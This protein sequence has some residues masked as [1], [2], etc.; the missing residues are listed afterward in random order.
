[1]KDEEAE[2][3]F[4]LE[5]ERLLHDHITIVEVPTHSLETKQRRGLLTFFNMVGQGP[6]KYAH[7]SLG[8]S[9]KVYAMCLYKLTKLWSLMCMERFS[10][11]YVQRTLI[12]SCQ[13]SGASVMAS[14][15]KRGW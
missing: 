10:P 12:R 14:V 4:A 2:L 7:G 1:M 6:N 9:W 11:L 3:E 15:K 8:N 5:M 13:I